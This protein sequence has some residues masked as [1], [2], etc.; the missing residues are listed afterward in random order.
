MAAAVIVLLVAPFYT[1]RE[2]QKFYHCTL[3]V[4]RSVAYTLST[5][6]VPFVNF[7]FV[8]I[9]CGNTNAVQCLHGFR[10]IRTETTDGKW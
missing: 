6:T 1:H 4:S 8:A 10:E 3:F 2:A 5:R 9:D 7:F